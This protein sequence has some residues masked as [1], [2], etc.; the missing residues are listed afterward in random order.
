LEV[1]RWDGLGRHYNGFIGN[2][3]WVGPVIPS[4][5]DLQSIQDFFAAFIPP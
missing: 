5:A 3:L 4:A 1:G 2:G